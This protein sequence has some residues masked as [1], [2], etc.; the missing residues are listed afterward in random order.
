MPVYTRSGTDS[1]IRLQITAGGNIVLDQEIG[2]TQQD[3]LEKQT[4]NWYPL[5]V[6]VPFARGDVLS[7]GSIRL[8][9]LG[10]DAW[11][12]SSL[13]VFG[14]DTANGGPNE[15]VTLVSIPEWDIDVLSMDASE[16]SASVLLPL[17]IL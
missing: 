1:P 8:S 3:D 4:A 17:A 15:V 16:G 12:P 5:D 7:N 2:D 6:L 9:I 11:V 14:L 10:S 13:F